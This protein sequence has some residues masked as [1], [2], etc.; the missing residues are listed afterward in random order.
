[1][2]EEVLMMD[3]H[4]IINN[5]ALR[6][7]NFVEVIQIILLRKKDGMCWNYFTH[8]LFSSN[9][10]EQKERVYLTDCPKSI[11]PEYKI[12]ITKEVMSKEDVLK[13]L[14]KAIKHQHWEW[15]EDNAILDDVFLVNPQFIPET[16]PT[17][18]KTSN[19][20]LVPIESSLY[21]SNFMGG[22]YISELFSAKTFLG[23][24]SREENKRI[25]DVINNAGINFRIERLFDRIGNIVCKI[26]VESIKHTSTRLSPKRGIAGKFELKDVELGSI[27]CILQIIL[28][29]D[30]TIIETRI[31]NLI[32]SKEEPIKEYIIEPNRYK[33]TIILSDKKSGIIF[34]SAI[35]DYAFGSNYYAMITPPQFGI[36]SSLKRKIVIDGDWKSI[37]VTNISGIGEVFVEKEIFEIE[38]RQ[39]K[40]TTDYEYEHHFFRS[41]I[42]GQEKEAVKTLIEICNDKDLLWDL[43]EIWLVDPYLSADDILKTVVYCEKYGITIKC[44]THIASIT[45]N[46]ATRI[47]EVEDKSRFETTVD[48]YKTILKN[49]LS[50]QND[51]KIEFRTVA[52]MKGIPF[53]DRYLILK[54][55]M[56]K[57]RVWSLG[58]SVNSMGKSH[59][60]IQIVQ[61]PMDVIE[62][63]DA[64]WVQSDSEECLIYCNYTD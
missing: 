3:F 16:D 59:H 38:K 32:L 7:C 14:Q 22:Y 11:G 62:T 57:S 43:E 64:I 27:E 12:I 37:G 48:K 31:E 54:Y 44:L 9:F 40:W 55:G 34:Y 33:N 39:H 18:S 53:H 52:G 50:E 61:S 28:E 35:R 36:Q 17:G 63:I 5:K 47:D 46:I 1:M 51:M 56:N 42:A 6:K 10:Q 23:T 45:G 26:P 4:S 8:I 41:F 15:K 2:L 24:L 49:A 19:S 60:I 25:Q 30:N 21:G 29:N 58:I 20:T 13:I